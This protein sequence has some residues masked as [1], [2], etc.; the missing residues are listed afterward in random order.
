MPWRF[1]LV[2]TLLLLPACGDEQEPSQQSAPS[3]P[4][5]DD[6]A[7]YLI[8]QIDLPASARYMNLA[9]ANANKNPATLEEALSV[10]WVPLVSRAPTEPSEEAHE[11]VQTETMLSTLQ[12]L[13]PVVAQRPGLDYVSVAF[14]G[15]NYEA[16]YK[17]LWVIPADVA[18]TFDGSP[19]A[20]NRLQAALKRFE[21]SGDTVEPLFGPGPGGFVP[22]DGCP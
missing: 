8:E 7:G 18:T 12:A 10:G 2:T 16:S 4:Q 9:W 3:L 15:C 17:T 11:A 21:L 14:T 22:P 5:G 13:R 6:V 20:T 19:E 1:L